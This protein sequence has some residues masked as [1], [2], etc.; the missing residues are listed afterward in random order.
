MSEEK[1]LGSLQALV[2][3]RDWRDRSPCGDRPELNILG[4]IGL[5][6]R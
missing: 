6:E 3:F 1:C 2:R 5:L 4:T